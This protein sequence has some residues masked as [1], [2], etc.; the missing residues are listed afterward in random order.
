MPYF[1]ICVL[2]LTVIEGEKREEKDMFEKVNAIVELVNGKVW[3]WGMIVLLFGTHI[4]LTIRTG[5]IQKASITKGIK[6]SVT[7]DEGA[8]GEVSQFGALTTALASMPQTD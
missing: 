2:F 5:F 1:G 7:K 8:E 6:L 3:G 4:F